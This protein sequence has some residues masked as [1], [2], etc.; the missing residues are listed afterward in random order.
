[1]VPLPLSHYRSED[2]GGNADELRRGEGGVTRLKRGLAGGST[3]WHES[4]AA[5]MT[6]WRA[7][8]TR[9]RRKGKEGRGTGGLAQRGMG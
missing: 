3:P 2:G 4:R 8:P 5:D 6:R 7:R 9:G 1:M